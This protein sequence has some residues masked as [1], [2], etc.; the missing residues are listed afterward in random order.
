MA[1]L[2]PTCPVTIS[3]LVDDVI[4]PSLISDAMVMIQDF[5]LLHPLLW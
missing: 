5:H 2:V 3:F 1:S 4:H